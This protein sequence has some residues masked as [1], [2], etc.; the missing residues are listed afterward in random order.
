[1]PQPAVLSAADDD[2]RSRTAAGWAAWVLGAAFLAAVV[3]G[4]LRFS[5]ERAFLRLAEQAEPW[6]LAM[7]VLLQAGTCVAQGGVW[8]RVA[9]GCGYSLSRRAAFE[10]SLARLFA[11]Q[12]LPSAGSRS[13]ILVAKALEQRDLPPPVV[14]ASVLINITSY[15]LAYVFALLAAIAIVALRGESNALI[16]GG[17]VLVVAFA[18][19]LS[20]AVLA[21]A[22]RPQDRIAGLL[23]ELP[24][25]RAAV[26]C[27]A[28]TNDRLVRSPRVLT[29]T[30]AMQAAI[31]VLEAATLWVLILALGERASVPG[32]FASFMIASLFRTIGIVPGGLGTFEATSVLMLRL[33]GVDLAVALSA[34]LLFRGLSFWL[35]IAPGYWCSRRAVAPRRVPGANPV[36]QY[37]AIAA[38]EVARRLE[39]RLAGLSRTEAAD[40]LARYGANELRARRQL[41]RIGVM[42]RQLRSP[43]LLLLV[44]AAGASALTGEWLDATIVVTIVTATVAFGYSR[45]YSAQAAA[46]A[47]RARLQVRSTV[48]RDGRAQQIPSEAIVPGDVVLLAA[49]SLVPADAVLLEATDFVVSEA[50]LTGES[51]P[52]QKSPGVLDATAALVERTNC[53]F[54]GTNVRSGTAR[55]LVVATG[56]ATEFGAVALRL[57]LRPPETEFDRGI[58]R[59]GILLTS[60]MVA[61]VIV[62][63][64]AHVFR[65]RAPVE[66]LLFAIALAVGLSPELL[67]AILSVNLARGA[68]MM[69]HRG[70]LVRRLNAIENLGSMDTLCTDK[71]GTL[72]EGVVQLEGAYDA[73]G[74][75]SDEV[76]DLG[77]SNATLETGIA[78]PL[79]DAI[80]K[81]RTPDLAQARKLGE[82]PFD[83][84]R[85]RVTVVIQRGGGA[86]L[87]TKGAFHQVLEI[88]SRSAD[89][90]ALTPAARDAVERRYEAWTRR[91]IRVLAVA[92]RSLPEQRM[93]GR[94]DERDMTFMGF[95]TFLDRPKDGV[96]QTIA[97]LAGMGVSVKLIT[98]DSR[99]VAQHVALLVGLRADHVLTGHQIGQLHDE[100]LARSAE[101][102]DLFVEVDPN[103]KERIVLALKRNG[104]VVGFLGD[105][106]ND[107]PAMHAADTSLSVEQ[108][109]DVARE[110]AD[111]VL[112]ER[113]LDVIRRGIAEGR[114]TFANTLKYVLMTTSAN[115]GNMVSMA[116]ASL[117]LPF[118]PLTAGQ[119]LLNNFLSDIPAIGIADDAVDAELV[120]RPRRWDIR[121][122]SRYMVEF[123]MLSSAF[124]VLTFAVLLGIYH[125][126]P[127]LFR[128]SWF[129]E[130]L[131]T[132][133]VV[134]LVMR[135]RRPFFRSRP[136]RL[137]STSTLALVAIAFAIP[138][139]PFAGA[140]GFVPLP[141]R[142]VVTIALIAALYVAATEL[143][144][145]SFYR[146]VRA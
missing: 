53:V 139:A 31:M 105:G 131:L 32:V 143:Q 87:V 107:A 94:D 35:P 17:A 104:H 50:V 78:S 138:Y 2:G 92:A 142:L 51:F 75:P 3:A 20:A 54:L 108:A 64:V 77:A 84:L 127:G 129:V 98:G 90:A 40:R 33:F 68:Q 43:L 30:I 117:F 109:V 58:R 69:A 37:W 61:M 122:I 144:K 15:R 74:R 11:D 62:V 38:V 24:A 115:L 25:V 18:L 93:Y 48:L 125:A 134:A 91:G 9:H 55:C 56:A 101:T 42:T 8:R 39:S 96:A 21:L 79:D 126:T 145:K 137:L 141:G 121:F 140:F 67:P 116:A 10:L 80:T 132:E 60:A 82:I 88:C 76:L 16:L 36:S 70:V 46:A 23:P 136:G 83:F 65:D 111:F 89:G 26:D 29:D 4:A 57:T 5:E 110:A 128:T 47:L 112:L 124:D 99:L 146:R 123:G 102:T 85:K 7:A 6:W 14:K 135:T 118:L 34:T 97:E 72:T 73:S 113:G 1:V 119:I 86:Q 44:F 81:A 95:L 63:F 19:G 27:L 71:T 133:L 114:R 66:T 103:Q 28:A 130:S 120:E 52:V 45:E 100:A 41:S 59:F 12:A 106:V 49:G 13:S 22:G